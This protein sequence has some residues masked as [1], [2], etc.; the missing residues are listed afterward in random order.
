MTIGKELS[1]FR[2]IV[3]HQQTVPLACKHFLEKTVT[4]LVRSSYA[5]MVYSV[6]PKHYLFLAFNDAYY[7]ENI[8]EPEM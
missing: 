8:K 7:V 4:F 5:S 1:V 3:I 2:I 6:P